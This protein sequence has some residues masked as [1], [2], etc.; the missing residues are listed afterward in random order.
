MKI[1]DGS[2]RSIHLDFH[3]PGFVPVGEKFNAKEFGDILEKANVNSISIFALCHHGYVYYPTEKGITHPLLKTDLL[4]G[5][6]EELKKR[7]IEALVYFSQN[8][9]ETLSAAHPE[10]VALNRDGSPVNSQILLS[11]DELYWSWLCPNRGNWVDEFFLP[12]IG[13]ALRKYPSDGVFVDMAGYLPGSCFCEAC[14]AKMKSEGL[15]IENSDQHSDFLVRTNQEVARKL[16]RLMDSVRPGLR[17][18]MGCFNRIGEAPLAKGVLSEFYL[19]TLPVQV[20]WFMFPFLARY[21]RNAELPVMGM[22]GRFLK[23]W[24]DFGTVK[25]AHQL[26]IELATHLA[27][28][29]SS[30]VGDHLHFN[31]KLDKAVYKI[32][33]EG[34]KFL[35]E[36]QPYCV[37]GKPMVEVA[38]PMPKRFSTSAAI[39]VKDKNPYSP[40]T[41][42]TGLTR[43]MTELHYQWDIAE[44]DVNLNSRGA[45]ILN[46]ATCEMEMI[47]KIIKFAEDGGLVIAS[48]EGLRA[49]GV[50]A[51]SK[52]QKFLG[53]KSLSALDEPGTYYQ[54]KSK[55][56]K[57]DMP[58]MP[59]YTHVKSLRMETEDDLECLAGQ[60]LAP[61]VRSR[62]KFYGH[63]HGAPDKKCGSAI[64]MR[65]TGKG[66]V[67]IIAPALFLS[68]MQ[69]GNP[70]H[71]TLIRNILNSFYPEE[72][73]MLRTNAPGIVEIALSEKDGNVVVQ[74]VPFVAGRR[75]MNSFETLNEAV[76]VHGVSVSVRTPFRVESV[77]DP[78]KNR[79]IKYTFNDGFVNFKLPPF[80]DHF[81]ALLKP[82]GE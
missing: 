81:L 19:E 68:Y 38:I 75:D 23:N 72:K 6:T 74:A 70:H 15:D 42:I 24:G 45:V 61:C 21:F 46:H 20:G 69:T 56:L 55:A 16:R 41:D 31:G 29:V 10:Y 43:M 11:G 50:E 27:A 47:D 59:L 14:R 8:V 5:M 2:T 73:R 78:L 26:K 80:K 62:E 53:I 7:G 67:I 60:M 54:V 9:N 44:A 48:Y 36:R 49:K 51:T 58:D 34:F 63:F 39:T 65:K 37:G 52:W 30:A 1:D 82:A 17:L 22:T 77:I 32:I 57:K 40:M 76:A 13:E 4:G 35:K 79:K 71:F 66:N 3:T 33:G 28:G 18:E 25:S 64:S 12:L